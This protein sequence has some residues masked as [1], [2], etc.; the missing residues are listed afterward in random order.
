MERLHKDRTLLT[1]ERALVGD[2]TRSSFAPGI[3]RWDWRTV[4]ANKLFAL[5]VQSFPRTSQLQPK[6]EAKENLIICPDMQRKTKKKMLACNLIFM[7]TLFL[8]NNGHY[9]WTD[10][11]VKS[12]RPCALGPGASPLTRTNDNFA[13][14]AAQFL[15]LFAWTTKE[16]VSSVHLIGVQSS[17]ANQDFLIVKL[18]FIYGVCMGKKK[19]LGHR[20]IVFDA[21]TSQFPLIRCGRPSTE[22]NDNPLPM[23][24]RQIRLT[25]PSSF[26]FCVPLTC[27]TLCGLVSR[28]RT[29][30]SSQT[31]EIS[32]DCFFSQT[33]WFQRQWTIEVHREQFWPNHV[34]EMSFPS[35]NWQFAFGLV[36]F[37]RTQVPSGAGCTVERLPSARNWRR[38]VQCSV[39]S[40]FSQNVIWSRLRWKVC[41]NCT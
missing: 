3:L 19:Q 23:S 27:R 37:A 13:L 12:C 17:N 4:A 35:R 32:S 2:Y 6:D 10:A 24:V 15:S 22:S 26:V 9:N 11:L 28:L 36:H 8:A 14:L 30:I 29:S 40:R 39:N 38:S 5:N 41:W 20:T 18:E 21:A 16:F 31:D 34:S 1:T 25:C 33:D 7:P